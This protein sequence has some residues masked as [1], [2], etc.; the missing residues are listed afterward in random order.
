MPLF[1]MPM[2]SII[3]T[4]YTVPDSDSGSSPVYMLTGDLLKNTKFVSIGG[5][6]IGSGGG[7]HNNKLKFELSPLWKMERDD[8][9]LIYTHQVGNK[10]Y[11]FY[12]M[13]LT[14]DIN[15]YTNH[16]YDSVS[17]KQERVTGSSGNIYEYRRYG[18]GGDE[19]TDLRW[20]SGKLNWYSWDF[21]DVRDYNTKN[22][23]YGGDVIIDFD[24]KQS[25]FPN[26]LTDENG[27]RLTKEFDFIGVS[28]AAVVSSDHGFLSQA[29]PDIRYSVPQDDESPEEKRVGPDPRADG[30]AQDANGDSY[31]LTF[32]TNARIDDAGYDTW[33]PG[34]QAPS[35]DSNLNPTLKNGDPIYD[36]TMENETSQEDCRIHYNIGSI[37]PVVTEYHGRLSYQT[38]L[39][40][41]YDKYRDWA[42]HYDYYPTYTD[43]T[44][45]LSTAIH[46]SNRYIHSELQIVLNV[47]SSYEI[48]VLDT[49]DIEDYNLE[50]PVEYYDNLTWQ[51]AVD[52]T[53]AVVINE[54]TTG[55]GLGEATGFDSFFD[56]IDGIFDM[57]GQALIYII[58]V[59]VII[60]AL[61]IVIKVT[62]S[63]KA[64]K[65]VKIATTHK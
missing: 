30:N 7:V 63:K 48:E 28:S 29:S 18:L 52:G 36:N 46:V 2:F 58:I 4:A 40:K 24:I 22:N 65:M 49:P 13:A 16:R 33:D 20:A 12:K 9:E 17:S 38:M 19:F 41:C 53:D 25:P 11:M 44:K 21:G 3:G 64:V 5:E 8:I 15:A 27:D 1:M 60:V 39:L 31:F 14:T 23:I 43:E 47:W 56:N 6:A 57:A 51:T 10:I 34:I 59:I 62:L 35:G 32:K 55:L 50:K 26:S 42:I 45:M 37:A 54:P 61:Y